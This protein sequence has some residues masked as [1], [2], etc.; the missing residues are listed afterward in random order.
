MEPNMRPSVDGPYGLLMVG[1]PPIPTN[2]GWVTASTSFKVKPR[3][4]VVPAYGNGMVNTHMSILSQ[5]ICDASAA[6]NGKSAVAEDGGCVEDR[7]LAGQKMLRCSS[8]GKTKTPDDFMKKDGKSYATC[9]SC[10]TAKS[11]KIQARKDEQEKERQVLHSL[12]QDNHHLTYRNQCLETSNKRLMAE[13]MYLRANKVARPN[14]V[15]GDLP[16]CISCVDGS[17]KGPLP[18]SNLDPYTGPPPMMGISVPRPAPAEPTPVEKL[19]VKPVV[20]PAENK[21]VGTP[22]KE[23]EPPSVEP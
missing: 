2:P 14:G 7:T 16:G 15:E 4:P 19:V 3:K 12:L 21:P 13:V 17:I 9:N 11:R 8:C 20:V 22:E 18:T 1:A 10:L 5:A 23:A 6:M